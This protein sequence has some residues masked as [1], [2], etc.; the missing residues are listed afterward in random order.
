MKFKIK[1][2]PDISREKLEN[3]YDHLNKNL[4]ELLDV[5]C[6]YRV[7]FTIHVTS[8]G[9]VS[10]ESR[11]HTNMHTYVKSIE[12]SQG[13]IEYRETFALGN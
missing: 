4:M 12:Q 8:D 5:S 11:E 2:E 9:K 1:A 13:K 3:I 10:L 6:N 7:D